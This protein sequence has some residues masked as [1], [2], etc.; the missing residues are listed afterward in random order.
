MIGMIMAIFI[1][2]RQGEKSQTQKNA[3]KKKLVQSLIVLSW[4]KYFLFTQKIFMKKKTAFFLK[5][6]IGVLFLG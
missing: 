3:G 1:R 4:H 2:Q 6:K 5:K